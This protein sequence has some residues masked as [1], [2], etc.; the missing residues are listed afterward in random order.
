MYLLI[1][2]GNTR[3]KWRL[4]NNK[5]NA[6]EASHYGSLEDLADFMSTL[7]ADE[8]QVLLAAVNQTAEL[9]Q[10]LSVNNFKKVTI[11]SSKLYEAGLRN[12]YASPERMGVDRWLA[13]IAAYTYVDEEVR[14]K[15][16][17]V[18]DAGSALTIDVVAA[19]GEHE[20]GYIV[21]GLLMAQGALFTNTERVIQY[22]EASVGDARHD[23]YKKLGNNTMQ[24]VEYGVIN[25]LLALIR[26]VKEEYSNY[27][28]FFTGGDGELLASYLKADVVDKDLVLKGLWQVRN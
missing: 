3:V 13:M 12:S 19:N 5:Y 15:G 20:G 14:H 27:E 22:D 4:V 11:A 24:C 16:I 25:Q 26:Q 23:N 2:V 17:I 18:V 6:G 7:D 10:L 21:P 8:T 9:K 28:V 1:D